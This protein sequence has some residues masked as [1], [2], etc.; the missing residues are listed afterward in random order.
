[1]DPET[2]D[3]AVIGAGPGG[4]T[5]ALYAARAKLTPVVFAGAP[6]EADP[7]RTPGGQLMTTTE[8]ENFPGFEAPI[9]GPELMER[10]ERQAIRAGA[11]VRH[12]NVLALDLEARPFRLRTDDGEIRAR[13]VILATGA[14]A[15]WLGIPGEEAY[16]NRGVS[17][18]A[19]CDGAL[20]TGEDVLVVGGG[21][22]AL[23]EAIYLA[24]M[25]RSVQVIHR[26]GE[27]RGSRALRDRA[28]ALANVTFRLDAAVV[29]I[30][31][32]ER[33]VT[34]ARVRDLRTGEEQVVAAGAV[35]V[36]VGHRP[37]TSLVAGQVE[38]DGEGFV[39][40]IPGRTRTY[41]PGLFACGDVQ[42]R[43]YRQAI[44]AAGTGA[45]AAIDAERW[46]SE[47]ADETNETNAK[48]GADR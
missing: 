16:R 39:R 42:D 21:D 22:S 41:V 45:M 47:E 48:Q 44:T 46:L 40:T 1:M 35:F 38:L 12:E 23:T 17:A 43:V 2:I 33:R 11:R 30:L 5:A 8:V 3:V 14:A 37:A 18:C 15:K 10:M 28:A 25:A 36:A 19:T 4:Y 9:A 32:D 29:E 31:G 7:A 26:R 27:L 24:R 6:S 20:F 13:A 34:G